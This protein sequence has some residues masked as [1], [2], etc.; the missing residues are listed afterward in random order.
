M[1]T[2]FSNLRE[3]ADQSHP[4]AAAFVKNPN[5]RLPLQTESPF[6]RIENPFAPSTHIK[7][8][9]EGTD[10]RREWKQ[11]IDRQAQETAPLR[12]EIKKAS[13]GRVLVDKSIYNKTALERILNTVQKM[14]SYDNGVLFPGYTIISNSDGFED[15]TTDGQFL[16]GDYVNIYGL[17][18]LPNGLYGTKNNPYKIYIRHA[19][20]P[21]LS[22]RMDN[23][24]IES[25]WH[26][27]TGE[28]NQ[29]STHT[30]EL[31]HSAHKEALKK[32]HPPTL[33]M[34]PEE[35]EAYKNLI[36]KF[37]SFRDLVQ[38]LTDKYHLENTKNAAKSVSGYAEYS[39]D[40][41]EADKAFP[42]HEM[43]AEAYSD[44]L[45][46]GNSARPYS[47]ALVEA[48]SEYLN[49]YNAIFDNEINRIRKQFNNSNNFIKNLRNSAPK[50][51]NNRY[52]NR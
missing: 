3:S 28:K 51:N 25:G 10:A 6:E 35:D 27:K 19:N 5:N 52:I 49:E 1:A 48:Y 29:S 36:S 33:W 21:E 23:D 24:N 43:F 32:S 15:E 34:S 22:D 14:K 44:V 12:E 50:F 30:H 31:S 7:E 26:P 9:I 4:D 47:K 2:F 38:K 18:P 13:N 42:F 39:H 37:S 11:N 41:D 17:A 8:F 46:N 45:N 16:A 20:I 40:E